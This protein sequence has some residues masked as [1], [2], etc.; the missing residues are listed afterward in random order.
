MQRDLS[1]TSQLR[2]VDKKTEN[3]ANMAIELTEIA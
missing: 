3:M 1:L 2:P